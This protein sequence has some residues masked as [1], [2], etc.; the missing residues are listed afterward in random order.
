MIDLVQKVAEWSVT[1]HAG[2]FAKENLPYI[3]RN[4]GM[5]VDVVGQRHDF[6]VERVFVGFAATVTV[7]LYMGHVPPMTVE[8]FHRFERGSPIARHAQIIGMDVNRMR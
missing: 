1:G 5:A 8:S 6:A 3:D 7:K 4:I 2:R